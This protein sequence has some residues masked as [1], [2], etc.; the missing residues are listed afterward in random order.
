MRKIHT[1]LVWPYGLVALVPVE[2]E[3]GGMFCMIT[4]GIKTIAA[5]LV[6]V[7]MM[8]QRQVAV[9]TGDD[10]SAGRA[11]N[12]GGETPSIE[13]QDHL[14][15]VGQSSLDL[16]MQRPRDHACL[17]YTSPSPRD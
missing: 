12:A 3:D 1:T 15:S 11:L 13:H 8:S 14:T 17:L 4:K 5:G 9:G 10:E 6:A 7:A 16:A 2:F